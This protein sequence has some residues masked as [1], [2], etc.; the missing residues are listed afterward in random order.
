MIIHQNYTIYDAVSQENLEE[1][2]PFERG[3]W[4]TIR[5]FCNFL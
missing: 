4:Y 1:K 3:K 2:P 5:A